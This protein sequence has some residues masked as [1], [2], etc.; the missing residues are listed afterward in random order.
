MKKV[1]E[2]WILNM[3]QRADAIKDPTAQD[4]RP[5]DQTISFRPAAQALIKIL[6]GRSIPYEVHNLGCGVVRITTNTTICPCC[7]KPL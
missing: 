6:V 7:N 1:N 5:I 2:N 4:R 3:S